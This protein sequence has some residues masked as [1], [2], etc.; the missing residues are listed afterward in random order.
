MQE[1]IESIHETLLKT[2]AMCFAIES[3]C[4]ALYK[5]RPDMALVEA[6]FH[7]HKNDLEDS[8]LYSASEHDEVF[9]AFAQAHANVAKKLE[10][11]RLAP[12]N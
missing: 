11:L 3:L 4:L 9:P 2:Q 10:T 12:G 5:T 7:A 6:A 8:L 1:E